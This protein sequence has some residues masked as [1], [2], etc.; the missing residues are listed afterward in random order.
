MGPP[1]I[2]VLVDTEG[3]PDDAARFLASL[4]RH[5]G[6]HPVEVIA[7][8]HGGE[9]GFG[10]A[11]NRALAQAT[12]EV[13]VL[14]DTSL[15]LTGDLLGDLVAALDDPTVAVTGP[16]GLATVDLCDY[17]E[18][19]AGDVAAVQGYCLATRRADLVAAGGVQEAFTW[20]R[21]A[22]IDVSLRLR[23]LD[24]PPV[25]RA[26][27]VGAG[28]CTRHTHRA[29]EATPEAERG[30]RSRHNMGLVHAVFFDRKDLA[31]L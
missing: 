11:Q 6:D 28:H 23:T 22:D 21:N 14:V 3:W 1:E 2:S 5:R 8:G 16:Y 4:D 25:R 19:T 30:E 17:E 26:V 7:A 20:Y 13:V 24:E 18:R 12:G 9:V 31:V 27:A 29:W 10:A 15:E